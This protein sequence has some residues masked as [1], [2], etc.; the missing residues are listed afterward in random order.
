VVNI[1]GEWFDVC[2]YDMR[3]NFTAYIGNGECPALLER[4]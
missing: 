4:G 3:V 2:S 1:N